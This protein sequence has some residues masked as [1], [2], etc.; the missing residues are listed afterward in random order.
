MAES[1]DRG[2]IAVEAAVIVPALALFITLVISL[3]EEALVRQAVTSA[4]FHGARAASLE[5]GSMAARN[6]GSDSTRQALRESGV[7]CGSLAVVVDAAGQR[8]PVGGLGSVSVTV[9]CDYEVVTLPGLP[10]GRS[11]T[12]TATSPVDPFRGR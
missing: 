11:F 10:G 3:A 4:A 12:D 5:R 2:H 6:A 1:G 8:A 7:E 9:S